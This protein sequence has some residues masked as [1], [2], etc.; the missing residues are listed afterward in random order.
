MQNKNKLSVLFV[1]AELAPLVKVGGL[2]DVMGA[3]P[4]S[5]VKQGVNV[6][7][8]IP[9]YGVIDAKKFKTKLVKK[10]IKF[11]I[12]GQPA[13]FDLYQTFLPGTKIIIFLVK[14]KLF[15]NKDIYVGGRRYMKGRVYSRSIGDIERFVFFSKAVAETIRSMKWK[16]DVVHAHD[17]H[18]ALLPTFIDEYSLEDKNFSNIKTLFTIHNLANQ[19]ISSLDIVDYGGLH[20][21]LTPALME[22]YYDK[23]GDKIDMMKIGILSADLINTVSPSYAKE[24]LTKEY[25]EK[26]ETYLLRRKKHLFGIVNGIDLDLFNPNKDKFIYK[27]YNAKNRKINKQFNKQALQAEMKLPKED[28]P[29]LGLVSR[30]VNQKGLDILVPALD[31]LLAKQD[32]QVIILGTGQPEHEQ[33]FKKLA[34]KYPTKLSA[35][36]TFNI[37]MA[38]KIYAGS[39]FFLMPSAFEPCGLGQ[40][41]AMRYGTLPLVRAT[42][43]LKDTVKHSI[44]GIVFK[45]YTQTAMRK[46]LEQAI[47]LYKNKVKFNKMVSTAMRQDFSWDQSAKEY[48]KLYKKLI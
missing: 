44:T 37:A 43:G 29:V 22:D 12:D 3:L 27:K 39:D 30:L 5:L 10:N 45:K 23:D 25:G 28:V 33:A 41:M 7:M 1:G 8:I 19:G 6:S 40:M 18:T 46:A 32:V 26:L 16:I 13:K 36:I 38:Q 2:G 14:H 9:F 17:W 4:K 21:D 11:N 34:K 48:I 24:I 15:I 20:H 42:G 31:K 47:R 35:N